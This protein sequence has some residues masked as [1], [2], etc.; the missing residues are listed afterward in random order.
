MDA[1][2]REIRTEEEARELRRIGRRSF[3]P[4]LS[5][6]LPKPKWAYGVFEDGRCLG[7]VLL[8]KSG[9]TGLIDWIFLGRDARGRGLAKQLVQ[10]ALETFRQRGLTT[11]AASVRDDNTASWNLFADRG[12]RAVSPIELIRRFGLSSA[13]RLSFISFKVVAYGFDLW[14]GS[15]ARAL[16]PRSHEHADLPDTAPGSDYT[17]LLWHL[18][19]NLLPAVA[20]IWLGG[21]DPLNWLLGLG[22]VI[23]ARLSFAYVGAL[24]FYRPMRLRASRGGY[25]V[26]VVNHL[27]G[28]LLFHPAYWHPK[29]PRWREPEYRRGLG[30]S[31]LLG[32][33]GTMGLML[34]ASLLLSTEI[35]SS[36]LPAGVAE[37]IVGVGKLI[38]IMELQPLFEAWSGRRI[39]RWSPCA[40]FTALIAGVAILVWA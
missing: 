3:H 20:A 13:A 36:P 4:V 11:V 29:A 35:L 8:K 16:E 38:L 34:A 28:G 2:I 40:Y 1:E 18:G 21:R 22:L 9:D 24:P 19:L 17:T 37:S 32:V 6:I 12:L 39:L 27:A 33:T 31:A 7:G 30:I 15:V 23:L 14:L 10:R 25:L 26:A 5:L